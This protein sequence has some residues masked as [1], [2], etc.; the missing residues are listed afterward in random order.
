MFD[1][2]DLIEQYKELSK[3]E[4]PPEK[5]GEVWAKIAQNA[6]NNLTKSP[7]RNPRFRHLGALGAACVA[8]LVAAVGVYSSRDL[9]H[10]RT[11]TSTSA[12][13]QGLQFNQPVELVSDNWRLVI[14]KSLAKQGPYYDMQLFYAGVK[15]ILPTLLSVSWG[16]SQTGAAESNPIQPGAEVRGFSMVYLPNGFANATPLKVSWNVNGHSYSEQFVLADAKTDLHVEGY[17]EYV[18]HDRQWNVTYAYET[19]V[20]NGFSYPTGTLLLNYTG[21]QIGNTVSIT[22]NSHAASQPMTYTNPSGN[23]IRINVDPTKRGMT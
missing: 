21:G 1:S 2:K 8:L 18:G 10:H 15:P 12:H 20:G 5:S 17:H 16:G 11:Q 9:L 4:L 6:S 23:S 13:G 14:Y 3:V 22:L 19:I 7:S